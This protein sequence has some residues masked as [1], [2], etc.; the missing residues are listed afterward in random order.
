M[1]VL[2]INGSPRKGGNTDSLL[3][4]TL[5]PLAEAGWEVEKFQLGGKK[6]R[7]C[8]A[9]MKCW[10]N[11]DGK[12]VVDNDPLNEILE[13]MVR[14]D[15]I[16]LGT[17]TYFTDVSTEIKALI[18]RAGFVSLANGGMLAGKIGAAVV[19]VRR[20]GATHAY[21][22]INHLFQ[23]TRMIIPGSTYWNMGY[24]LN[25]GDVLEDTE[26]LAN[27]KNLGEG[28]AWLGKAIKPHMDTFPQAG[29][30]HRDG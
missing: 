13:K 10:E 20:G 3:D 6:I 1:Y 19:A 11:R 16:I 4:E 25:K 24:G 7:G 18:D 21:D 15:A 23:I 27:M 17:P 26:G 22:T 28:I 9:C 2:A 29:P 12:C 30:N 14:A 8:M 5:K